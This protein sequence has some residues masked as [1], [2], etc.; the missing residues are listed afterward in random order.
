VSDPEKSVD[1]AAA[2]A[3]EYVA[4]QESRKRAFKEEYAL[5]DMEAK[6]TILKHPIPV[7]TGVASFGGAEFDLD[8]EVQQLAKAAEKKTKEVPKAKPKAKHEKPKAEIDTETLVASVPAVPSKGTIDLRGTPL[9]KT[10]NALSTYNI[11]FSYDI[12]HD[13]YLVGDRA[14]QLR[15]GENVDHAILVLRTEIIRKFQFEPKPE[16]IRS[17]VYRMCVGNSFDPMRDYLDGLEWDGVKRIDNWLM[18]H[19]GATDDELNRA[20]GRKV[21]V[22]AVRRIKSP[23]AKFD[24]VLVLEGP[25][26]LGKSTA[27]KVLAGGDDFF[28]DGT[29]IFVRSARGVQEDCIG[30]WLYEIPE[31]DLVLQDEK[32][33]RRVKGF[34]SR[35]HDKARPAWG[36]TVVNRGR[37][38]IFIATCNSDD[39]LIPEVGYRRFWPVTVGKI[40]L[41]AL[42]RDRD[43]L[44]AEAVVAEATGEDLMIDQSLWGEAN[45]RAN[46]RRV[47][48]PWEDILAR[49]ESSMS[50]LRKLS[51]EKGESRVA[52]NYLFSN[53]LCINPANIKVP[54]TR[55][56]AGIMRRLGW[57]GPKVLNINGADVKGYCK[58][59]P[60]RTI[61]LEPVVDPLDTPITAGCAVSGPN[62]PADPVPPVDPKYAETLMEVMKRNGSYDETLKRIRE[63]KAEQTK[64]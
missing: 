23:G 28:G 40:D 6:T 25:E 13:Q 61:N 11:P 43:Q 7:S 50:E 34:V 16:I 39:Y 62:K 5:A 12:F 32:A 10:M 59:L 27:I 19:L 60:P 36:R 35:T 56:V 49:V 51:I 57:K 29:D 30:V 48:D 44:W 52:S 4:E 46:E 47:V 2:V 24:Q 33:A 41:E 9:E 22:A 31:I 55:R 45:K 1:A 38:F 21:L 63:A 53:F 20:I 54:D 8:K 3:A 42:K 37:R 58:P 15:I 64:S 14:L 17:A 18:T 26:G